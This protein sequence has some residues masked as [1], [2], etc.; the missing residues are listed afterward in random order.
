MLLYK[1]YECCLPIFIVFL[2]SHLHIYIYIHVSIHE[3]MTQRTNMYKDERYV[4][5]W[6][7]IRAILCG[8]ENN[9]RRMRDE[10]ELY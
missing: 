8:R 3:E 7:R 2:R 10:K 6:C 9:R 5:V 4:Y 1:M